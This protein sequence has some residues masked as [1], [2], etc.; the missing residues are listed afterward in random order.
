MFIIIIKY[1]ASNQLQM[2]ILA[3]LEANSCA[4]RALFSLGAFTYLRKASL[5]H[6]PIAIISSSLY[7]ALDMLVAI[8]LRKECDVTY[9]FISPAMSPRNLF[10]SVLKAVPV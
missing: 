7:P 10:K 1:K 2:A 3:I 5:L 6:L 8:P 9:P 4:T